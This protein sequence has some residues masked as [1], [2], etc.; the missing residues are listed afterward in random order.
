MK[1]ISIVSGILLGAIIL[2]SCQQDAGTVGTVELTTSL[3]T[4]SYCIGLSIG[5]NLKNSP[6]KEMNYLALAEGLKDILEDQETRIDPYNANRI[7]SVYMQQLEAA[8]AE[9]NLIAGENF[10]KNNSQKEGIVTTQSGLQY[11]ILKE[12]TG[13]RPQAN[14]L[15]S[16]HYHG[17]LIDGTVFD[18]SLDGDPAQF[19][20]NRV[21]K[22]W[23]EAIQLMPVGSKWE[24]FIPADLGYGPRP[25][26]GSSI[27]P[28]EV[29][30]F[31]VELF[32]IIQPAEEK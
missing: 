24:V 16:V 30:I 28:N 2:G 21:I 32:D 22:G 5:S 10:L 9:E 15:V 29:L 14:D 23:Q 4:V 31:E 26:P 11:K 3:D 18:S 12:G 19:Q 25:M 20:V 27:G 7:I 13:P 1:V 8:V 6:M 17:T